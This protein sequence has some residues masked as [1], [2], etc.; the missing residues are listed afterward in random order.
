MEGTITLR[1]V[2]TGENVEIISLKRLTRKALGKDRQLKLD[3][4]NKLAGGLSVQTSLMRNN[5]AIFVTTEI[6]TF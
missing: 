4:A 6:E 1:G 2:Y 3:S 5:G